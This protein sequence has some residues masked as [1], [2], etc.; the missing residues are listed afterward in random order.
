MPDN[1][2]VCMF[3]LYIQFLLMMY[4]LL[5]MY[6]QRSKWPDLLKKDLLIAGFAVI[7]MT[8]VILWTKRDWDKRQ[9]STIR[10]KATQQI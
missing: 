8:D 9:M 10:G 6:T 1:H 3:F 7:G 2:S 5:G 4:I